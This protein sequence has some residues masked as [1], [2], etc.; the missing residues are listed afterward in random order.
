MYLLLL[1]FVV[2]FSFR[3]F[4]SKL[5]SGRN[6]GG[7]HGTRLLGLIVVRVGVVVVIVVQPPM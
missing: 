1:S 3:I 5:D 7:G 4:L 6:G 2:V